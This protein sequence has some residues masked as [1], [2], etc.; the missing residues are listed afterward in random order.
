[1]LLLAY[2][3]PNLMSEYE[4]K[5]ASEAENKTNCKKKGEMTSK[6]SSLSDEKHKYIGKKLY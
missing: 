5:N 4:K 1:M 2:E 3:L 6:F